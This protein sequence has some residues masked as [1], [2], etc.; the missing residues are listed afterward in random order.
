LTNV[1]Q[2]ELQG[3]E[4]IPAVEVARYGYPREV[5]RVGKRFHEGGI[6]LALSDDPR[7]K[8][9]PMLDSSQ[10]AAIVALA[11]G[12]PPTGRAKWSTAVL[13]PEAMQRGIVLRVGRETIRILLANHRLKPWREKECGAFQKSTGN[14]LTEWG[15]CWSYMQGQ[16]TSS[17]R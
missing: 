7:P 8:P 10:E 2:S 9:S 17:S 13:A 14:S 11:C 12:P 4:T 1:S 15:T 16:R 5:S 6:Q 3:C